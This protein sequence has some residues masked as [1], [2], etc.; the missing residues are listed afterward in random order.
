MVGRKRHGSISVCSQAPL[1]LRLS[2]ARRRRAPQRARRDSHSLHGPVGV[3]LANA[4]AV[5][6]AIG[7]TAL[8]APARRGGSTASPM[9]LRAIW[10]AVAL[11]RSLAKYAHL[12][13]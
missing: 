8:R 6:P 9:I 13:T 3:P 1:H 5:D 10:E 4:R 11:E 2:V 7:I 12:W